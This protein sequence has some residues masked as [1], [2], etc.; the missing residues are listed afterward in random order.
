M[1]TIPRT[2]TAS[3]DAPRKKKAPA[4]TVIANESMNTANSSADV[5]SVVTVKKR[6]SRGKRVAPAIQA[7]ERHHLI[8]VAA[9]YIAERRGFH[10][11]SS[12]DDWLLA[13]QEIDAMIAQGRFAG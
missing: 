5:A 9:Y 3:A 6:S 4:K 10:G 2:S 13:E 11:E 7:K 12:H 1:I 8:E